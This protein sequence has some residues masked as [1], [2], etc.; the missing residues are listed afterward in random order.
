MAESLRDNPLA[1]R[2]DVF[3][4]MMALYT[5]LVAH[6]A[7]GGARVEIE[8][9]ASTA[10]PVAA[11]LE[12]FARPLFGL[13]PAAAGGYAIPTRDLILRGLTHGA[14]PAHRE[15]WGLPTDRSQR[16]VEASAIAT[17]LLIAPD[18]FWW[19]LAP[20]ARAH[21]T[22]W[23]AA[24]RDA[25]HFDNSW[26]GMRALTDLAL[27]R[28]AG[29]GDAEA[30]SRWRDRIDS[31]HIGDGWYRDGITR[32]ADHY[33]GFAIHFDAL[34]LAVFDRGDG[35]R[36]DRARQ[37]AAAF[38]PQFAEWF[39]DDGAALPFGRSLA[40]RF[41]CAAF[42][43]ALAFAGVEALP[44][45]EIKGHWLRHLRWWARQPMTR[46]DGLLTLGYAYPNAAL[47]EDYMSPGSPWWAFRTFLPLA[48][49]PDHPFWRAEEAVPQRTA[50]PVTL[51]APGMLVSHRPGQTIALSSGQQNR[52]AATAPR[53]MP[54]SPIPPATASAPRRGRIAP[55]G[56]RS[57]I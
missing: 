22:N 28:L 56:R 13:A 4:A 40:W 52:Q 33:N 14:D 55:T 25:E 41:G 1:T 49:P 45:G 48:L 43:G 17:G 27:A 9:H 18:A 15:Y 54:N 50:A 38:A 37:R 26:L 23:L 44:W 31:F 29:W 20:T 42:W 51:A 47:V 39:A 35:A 6:A 21:L 19:P 34:L 24:A 7:P 11:A 8:P 46:R 12:G 32:R 16:L 30:R 57:T 53:H 36:G 10:D 3:A 2:D 5:P